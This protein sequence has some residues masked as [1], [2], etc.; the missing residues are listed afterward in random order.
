MVKIYKRVAFIEACYDIVFNEIIEYVITNEEPG[1]FE[2]KSNSNCK[3]KKNCNRIM[4][5]LV[6][7]YNIS[8]CVFQMN[9]SVSVTEFSE[10]LPPFFPPPTFSSV[11][12]GGVVV[13][14]VVVGGCG[15]TVSGT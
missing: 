2:K 3:K 4:Q 10:V 11:R 14:V 7:A 13:V 1:D 6:K 5:K 9:L 12:V 15:G 8:V